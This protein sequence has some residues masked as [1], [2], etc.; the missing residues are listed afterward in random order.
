[1]TIKI[2]L[3]IHFQLTSLKSK[4]FCS[5]STDYRGKEANT[6]VCPI[7]LGLPGTLPLLNRKGLE[8]ALMISLALDCKTPE[9]VSFYRKNYF[10]PDLPKNFQISQYNSYEASSI[11]ID[12]YMEFDH[13]KVRI[14]R[15][16]LEEDPGRLV[17]EGSMETS[18][19]TLVDYNRAGVPLVEIVTEPDFTDPK[20]VR[21]FLNKLASTLEHLGICDT[22]LDGAVRC[23]ANVSLDK[24]KRVE[25]KNVSSFREVEK[26]LLF[27]ISR[28]KS[29]GT[30]GIEIRAET[31]HWD[32]VR[33]VT[34]QS[35]TKEEEQD[36]RYFPEPDVPA[37]NFSSDL[38]QILTKQ[39]PELPDARKARFVKKFGLSNQVAQ[40]LI[41]D[42]N[43]ADFF[44]EGSK[45]YRN[46]KEIANWIVTD[47]KGYTD[48]FDG[49]RSLKIKPV[50]VAELAK[51]V[52]TAVISRSTAK[53]IL[54]EIVKSG[55]MPSQ[56]AKRLNAGKISDERALANV[57]DDVFEKEREAVMDAL[58]NEKA[59]NF[60]LGKVM[61]STSA[62]ADPTLARELI[63]KK[64]ASISN[65]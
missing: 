24:G 40:V 25:I 48:E 38:M 60:L 6:N 14:R 33:R 57:I 9:I 35:R 12:G 4:L 65:A 18:L 61:E 11:G 36:Y 20:Q 45:I 55:E 41:D 30:K 19:Y 54:Q 26:A 17:Y 22:K 28:Q 49:I 3:E 29:L 16:Q 15:L 34:I 46:A 64:L 21:L 8:Y 1:M 31:R 23:D 52:D 5:C 58:Q 56:V 53:Q 13:K 7:C 27:E 63:K 43:L 32:D 2:G 59:L 62:R 39:M 42:K 44:E 10:Y 37:V 47:L 50:H 51:M